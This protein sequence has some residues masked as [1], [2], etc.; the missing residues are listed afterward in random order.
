MVTLKHWTSRIP[1]PPRAEDNTK[2]ISSQTKSPSILPSGVIFFPQTRLLDAEKEARTTPQRCNSPCTCSFQAQPD[3]ERTSRYKRY[4]GQKESSRGLLEQTKENLGPV[5]QADLQTENTK[6]EHIVFKMHSRDFSPGFGVW[7]N[8]AWPEWSVA[9]AAL[10]SFPFLILSFSVP[11]W[12]SNK[13]FNLNKATGLTSGVRA[14]S[15]ITVLPLL[16]SPKVRAGK[17]TEAA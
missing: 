3:C 13:K 12:M 11:W 5:L 2:H 8:R 15:L 9:A 6:H 10:L 7:Q 4:L 17:G 16:Q 14:A 1:Q